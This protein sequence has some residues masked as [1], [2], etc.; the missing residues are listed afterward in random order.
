MRVS[1]RYHNADDIIATVLAVEP[2]KF[3]YRGRIAVFSVN[4]LRDERVCVVAEQKATVTEEDVCH[5]SIITSKSS[6]CRVSAG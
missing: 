3:V 4:V 6:N 2:M 5:F 1:G